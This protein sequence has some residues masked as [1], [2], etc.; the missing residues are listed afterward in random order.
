[1]KKTIE[2]TVEQARKWYNLPECKQV[3][4][5]NFTQEELFPPKRKKKYEDI[6][7]EYKKLYYI[8]DYSK[9]S[10]TIH[11]EAR[12]CN[13]NLL[14][15]EESC[16]RELARM[17]AILI[18]DYYNDG[19]KPDWKNNKERKWVIEKSFCDLIISCS[20]ASLPEFKSYDLAKEALEN[21]RE[22]FE[23]MF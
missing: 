21:N 3:I 6:I 23:A 13:K 7:K 4:Q 2:I 1:M 12:D 8:N 18:A 20:Y 9:I 22:I 11:P 15:S 5:D 14:P 16:K 19:W 10:T 17:Q